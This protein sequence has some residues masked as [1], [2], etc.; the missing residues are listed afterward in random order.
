MNVDL[1]GKPIEANAITNVVAEGTS[2][3]EQPIPIE[4]EIK[5][6]MLD[7]KSIVSDKDVIIA[8]KDERIAMLEM[9]L[10]TIKEQLI[11]IVVGRDEEVVS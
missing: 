5:G 9:T 4:D 11:E 2:E 10:E 1:N 8:Q 3:D 7:L 6:L